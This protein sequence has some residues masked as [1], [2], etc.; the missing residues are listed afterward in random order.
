MVKNLKDIEVTRP[1]GVN[2]TIDFV[3]LISNYC[4]HKLLV[5]EDQNLRIKYPKKYS[6]YKY[7]H[8]KNYLAESELNK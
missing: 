3:T 6:I 4:E 5:G 7:N 8:W 2:L 1:Y